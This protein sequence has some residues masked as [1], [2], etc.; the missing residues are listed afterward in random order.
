MTN[1]FRS[2]KTIKSIPVRSDAVRDVL[3]HLTFDPKVTAIDHF[4]DISLEDA[5]IPAEAI[6]VKITMRRYLLEIEPAVR[7]ARRVADYAG[8]LG[9]GRRVITTADIRRLPC[10]ANV[11][12]IWRHA[13]GTVPVALRMR[14][15]SQLRKQGALPMAEL[16]K[17]LREFDAAKDALMSLAC[18]GLIRIDLNA[19]LSSGTLIRIAN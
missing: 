1:T 14:V 4:D 15:F 19:P 8:R 12:E 5:S 13:D 11:Q 3:V 10:Y 17:S 16:M 2:F 6:F 18:F 9:I 7:T